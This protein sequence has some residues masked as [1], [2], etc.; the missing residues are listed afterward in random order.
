M[1][2]PPK[3]I[4]NFD[5]A[6]AMVQAT[7]RFLKGKDFPALGLS[8]VLK[9]PAAAANILPKP[10]REKLYIFSGWNE[11]IPPEKIDMVEAEELAQWVADSYPARRYQAV[12]IGSSNGAAVHLN[13][14]LGIPWLP[15]TFLIPVRQSVHPDDPKQA[16]EIGKEPATELLR[17][18]PDLQLHHMHDANQ[19]RLMIREMTYFRVKRRALG[20]TFE[21]FLEERLPP[22]GTIFVI[23]CEQ[24]WGVTRLGERYVFQHGAVGGATEDEFHHGSDRVAEY[25]ARYESPYRTWDGP[26]PTERV[27][28]AEWGFEPA[29]LDDITRVAR[30][31][32]Y[33]VVRMR[34]PEPQSLS[35][36]VADLYRWWYERRNIPSDKRLLLESFV[37][38]EPWWTLATASVPFWMEFNMEASLA[39]ANDYIDRAGPFEEILMML[40]NHGV[41]AVGLPTSQEWDRVIRRATER[42]EWLGGTPWEFP[43]DYAQFS[44]Y[45]TELKRLKPR[46]PVPGYLTLAAF[47]RFLA[48]HGQ[49]YA[50]RFKD[51]QPNAVAA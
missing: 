14:A 6:T 19:D 21:R 5:S 15:Q 38:L 10:V 28:E 45:H 16:M 31:R 29:L 25:L 49:E 20:P 26:E 12:A 8:P 2:K 37:I 4:A 1:S 50:V 13:A 9:P 22:G 36:L 17:R 3:F 30:E 40:F 39:A 18:N 51:E 24:S 11:S 47:E 42:G 46:Y 34:F 27:P 41:E 32:H 33:R 44:R 23:D 48:E 35:P 43:M 7:A